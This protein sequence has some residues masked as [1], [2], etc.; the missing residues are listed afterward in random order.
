MVL[1]LRG[2]RG[3][4]GRGA[5]TTSDDS[6]HMIEH[7]GGYH[8]DSGVCRWYRFHRNGDQAL[9]KPLVAR[10]T[11]AR[12]IHHCVNVVVLLG[13]G[14]DYAVYSSGSNARPSGI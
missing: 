13:Y 4:H 3:R 11:C 14:N 6:H 7:L 12:D 2:R 1:N 9:G 10:R 5:E 8:C